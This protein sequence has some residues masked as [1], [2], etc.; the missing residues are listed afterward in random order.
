[1]AHG[2][3]PLSPDDALATP[4]LMIGSVGA[5]IERMT[6]HRERWGFS[7][8]TV[9]TDALGRIEPIIAEPSGH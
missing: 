7:H 6:A 8:C 3:P 1:M 4:Y 9:R 5:I 2:I